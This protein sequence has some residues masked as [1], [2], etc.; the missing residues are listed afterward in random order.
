MVLAF[1]ETNLTNFFSLT[2]GY[3]RS[4]LEPKTAYGLHQR[5]DLPKFIGGVFYYALLCLGENI[6][7]QV[8][9][10]IHFQRWQR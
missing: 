6:Q 1:G 8:V 3:R 7:F 10:S 4:V 9:K 2:K 5:S